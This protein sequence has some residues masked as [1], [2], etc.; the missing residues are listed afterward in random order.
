MHP[1]I[2]TAAAIVLLVSIAACDPRPVVEV[3]GESLQG[4]RLEGQRVSAF[5][6]I[7]FAEPPLGGLRWR[8]PQPLASKQP[9]RDATGFA[10]ACMQ[11]MRIVEWYRDVA[12]AFGA[13]RDAVADLDVSEDCLYLNVWTPSLDES[14]GLPVMIYV[15][16]GSN[17]SGWSFEPN[18]HGHVLADRGI[19]AVSVA[20]RLGAFG[21][22]SHPEL[23]DSGGAANFGLLDLV[24]ALRW[25]REHIAAFGGD[26]DRVTL[27]GESAGAQNI[28]ALMTSREARGLFHGA[29]LQST[30]GFGIGRRDSP[31][32]ADE[33]ERGKETTA[34]FGI[35]GAAT[36][37]DLRRIPADE[38]LRKYE[39][40]FVDYYHSPV[41]DGAV[42]ETSIWE[43]IENGAIADVPLIIGTT[44]D[45][46]YGST[47]ED[48]SAADVA[49][50]VGDSAFL[51]SA[52][53]LR[54][55]GTEEDP[56]EAMDRI[57][58]AD[59]MLCP[60]RLIAAK[61]NAGGSAAWMYRFTRV[62]EGAAGASMR[63]YHG[64][65]LPYVFGT[66][67]AWFPTT[68][69]DRELTEIIM[70][71]WVRFAARG[72]PNSAGLPEWPVFAAPDYPVMEFGD[73]A[74]LTGP[75]E[76]ALC[77]VFDDSIGSM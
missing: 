23:A 71:Y 50:S 46:W 67:D 53:A 27:F 31:S 2:S 32:L 76:P 12:E 6:G 38:L 44:A 25:V 3:D 9:K 58:T 28:L 55:V 66:H 59:R 5:R 75:P 47:P 33:R 65:E 63:A 17:K 41:V 49:A 18:Y 16:G 57:L 4:I 60:S 68:D 52:E 74:I 35:G 40:A 22:F 51:N 11:S 45:E 36:L 69:T 43:A 62:R 39:Q 29:I 26:P 14:A 24:A 1:G 19:V 34:L 7:P 73:S 56:R 10:P 30:A 8:P 15:H 37:A 21:F 13:A 70:S 61:H 54:L 48:A 64:A 77:R 72:D 20:Y 42:L